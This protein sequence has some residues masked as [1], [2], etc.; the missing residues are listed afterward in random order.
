V[1]VICPG[2]TSDCLET[3]EEIA[4]EAKRDFLTAGG[5]EFHYIPCLNEN[6][7][8]IAALADIAQQHMSG[9]P[10]VRTTGE[11]EQL[12]REAETGRKQ[13]LSMGAAK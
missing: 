2:F 9:W 7:A 13:A 4:M 1:A 5:T 12:N 11:R 3:L 6:P 10:T 8:W